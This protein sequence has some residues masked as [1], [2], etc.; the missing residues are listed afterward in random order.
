MTTSNTLTVDQL[1]MVLKRR[2]EDN[3]HRHSGLIWVQ[4]EKRLSKNP[5]KFKTLLQMEL[6]GGEP[7]VV[8]L[9]PKTDKILFMDCSPQSPKNRRSVCYD[10]SAWDSRKELKPKA[11]NALSLSETMGA[12]LLTEDQYLLLQSV[13][14]VDTTSSSWILTPKSIRS[15]GGALFG[16]KRYGRAFI[17]HNGAE[18]YYAERGF[19]TALEI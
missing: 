10:Q 18:S 6:T 11:G 7:D 14:D 13:D 15:L 17:F 5:S 8:T 1:M 3:S 4:V 2:F 12:T 19:R 16:D 9:D